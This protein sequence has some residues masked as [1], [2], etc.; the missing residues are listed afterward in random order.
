MN[1]LAILN[2]NNSPLTMTSQ[3]IADLTERRHDNVMRDIRTMLAELHGEGGVLSFEDTHTNHQN[4]QS[5]PIYRLP[6]RETLILVSGY[7]LT[8]RA[9]IIDRWQQL[10]QQAANPFLTMDRAGLLRVALES[11]EKVAALESK[12]AAD[13]PK[14]G[15]F[16]RLIGADGSLCMRDSA[17]S[18][19][20][21]PI[22]LRNLLVVERWIYGRPGHSGWL[23]YQD[24][25]QQGLLIHKV[26]TFTSADGT[27]KVT[28]QVR[29]TAKGLAKIAEILQPIQRAA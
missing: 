24:R 19:Q 25:I 22:D 5:Y 4:G 20:V 14:V 23:A 18:L 9:A 17:K 7:K 11:E 16:D 13:A 28:E 12:V 26:S 27:E 21:R 3:E 15:C 10:E 1:A 6:K 29:I 2:I 8:L